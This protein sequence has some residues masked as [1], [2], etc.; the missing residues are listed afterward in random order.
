MFGTYW[1]LANFPK[2]LPSMPKEEIVGNMSNQSDKISYGCHLWQHFFFFI[3]EFSAIDLSVAKVATYA[4]CAL[5][6][7]SD[8]VKDSW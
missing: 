5:I 6:S 7:M 4:L 8:A 1:D 2:M 3:L